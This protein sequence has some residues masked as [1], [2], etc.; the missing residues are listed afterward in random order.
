MDADI[1]S[2][3]LDSDEDERYAAS[4]VGSEASEE[5]DYEP[6]NEYDAEGY[7]EP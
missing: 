3:D 5:S 1:A 2:G 7:A 6:L 4:D